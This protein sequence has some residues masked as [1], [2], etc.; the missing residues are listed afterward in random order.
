MDQSVWVYRRLKGLYFFQFG[1][2]GVLFPVMPLFFEFLGYRK[3]EIGI[4]TA[5]AP[6]TSFI[7]G[8]GFSILADT[9]SIHGLLTLS[10]HIISSTLIYFMNYVTNYKTMLCLVLFSMIIRAPVCM[11]MDSHTLLLIGGEN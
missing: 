7:F 2:M 9:Y 8:P 3:S 11:Q 10:C 4:L 5:L 6:A 1:S